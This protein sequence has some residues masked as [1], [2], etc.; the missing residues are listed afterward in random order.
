MPTLLFGGAA[1]TVLIMFTG[2][3]T[4][5]GPATPPGHDWPVHGQERWQGY[6]TQSG[7]S[8][9]IT[10]CEARAPKPALGHPETPDASWPYRP[11]LSLLLPSLFRGYCQVKSGHPRAGWSAYIYNGGMLT[12]PAPSANLTPRQ[13]LEAVVW[14]MQQGVAGRA[15]PETLARV[16]PLPTVGKAGIWQLVVQILNGNTPVMGLGKVPL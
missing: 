7:C 3:R 5:P 12:A 16:R 8:D 6:Y 2:S 1:T 13:A 15:M 14:V 4:A 9:A 10:A 11:A